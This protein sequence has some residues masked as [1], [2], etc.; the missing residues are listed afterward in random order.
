MTIILTGLG[1]Y[2]ELIAS[3]LIFVVVLAAALVSTKWLANYQKGIRANGNIEIVESSQLTT[4]KYL[5]IVRIGEKYIAIAVCKD[6][7]TMLCEISKEELKEGTVQ[8][9]NGPDFKTLLNR[10][11][12]KQEQSGIDE[13]ID[14]PK[15]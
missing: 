12:N 4:N 13:H 14:K 5:Q 6:T 9:Y 1:G 11:K 10:F 2:L 7:V 8:S 15:E 3:L